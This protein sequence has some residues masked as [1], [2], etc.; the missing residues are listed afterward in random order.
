MRL[1]DK[2]WH[3]PRVV[4][5]FVKPELNCSGLTCVMIVF[6]NPVSLKWIKMFLFC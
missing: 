1:S 3:N 4:V 5:I 2:D 6:A